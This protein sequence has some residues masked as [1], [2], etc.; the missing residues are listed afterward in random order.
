MHL[1]W[2]NTHPQ[3]S[4]QN[5]NLLMKTCVTA[6]AKTDSAV[7]DALGCQTFTQG[8]AM[9]WEEQRTRTA[10]EQH[11]EGKQ[12]CPQCFMYHVTPLYRELSWAVNV[13]SICCVFACEGWLQICIGKQGFGWHSENLNMFSNCRFPPSSPLKSYP[14]KPS[15]GKEVIKFPDWNEPKAGH[16]QEH[17]PVKSVTMVRPVLFPQTK[18]YL[19]SKTELMTSTLCHK[20][21]IKLNAKYFYFKLSWSQIFLKIYWRSKLLVFF[22][23]HIAMSWGMWVQHGCIFPYFIPVWSNSNRAFIISQDKIV[24]L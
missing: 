1:T 19:E 11:L 6:C 16:S 9:S 2:G 10:L 4:Q 5:Q 18:A 15:C 13:Q 7:W 17:I 14:K 24:T 3:L 8:S 12:D 20:I 21:L 22:V 23:L